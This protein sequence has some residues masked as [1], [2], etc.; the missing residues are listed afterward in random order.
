MQFNKRQNKEEK[1]MIPL[2]IACV[3][4]MC[5]SIYLST[6]VRY[7]LKN[8]LAKQQ[9]LIKMDEFHLFQVHLCTVQ[10]EEQEQEEV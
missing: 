2:D 5:M 10:A 7:Y 9:T 6:H 1:P 3:L 8:E 4:I